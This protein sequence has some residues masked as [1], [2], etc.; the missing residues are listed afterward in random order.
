V[1]VHSTGDASLPGTGETLTW[2][3][4]Q[5]RDLSRYAQW[6]GWLGF[7]A[8]D[9]AVP[10][11][12][13]YEPTTELGMVRIFPSQ[14]AR[15]VKLFGFAPQQKFAGVYTDDGSGYV[16]MWGGLTPTF[17]D[18]AT[19]EP[20]Q[21]VAYEEIWYPVAQC[22]GVSFANDQVALHALGEGGDLKVSLFSPA[23]RTGVLQ[24]VQ[25][26]REIVEEPFTVYPEAPLGR[27]FAALGNME[28]PLTV[29]IIDRQGTLIASHALATLEE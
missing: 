27:E 26:Q 12:A 28:E 18:Y 6:R 15:G 23:R 16:E 17:W 11:T 10:F 9:L 7:F 4:Y 20:D 8:P 13:V 19:L 24:I 3:A 21:E 14:V 1:I 29:H 2:P 25:G 22:G 5:G